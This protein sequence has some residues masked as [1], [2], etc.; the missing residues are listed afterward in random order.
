MADEK[1]TGKLSTIALVAMIFGAL[2]ALSS[3]INL[4][5]LF[6]V[7]GNYDVV[8]QNL[9]GV[10]TELVGTVLFPWLT[11][12]VGVSSLAFKRAFAPIAALATLAGL[13]IQLFGT[14]VSTFF[15]GN[16]TRWEFKHELLGVNSYNE[17][18]LNDWLS[19][20]ISKAGVYVA[21][22]T[23][24]YIL[25][26]FIR[27]RSAKRPKAMPLFDP[28]TGERLAQYDPMTGEKL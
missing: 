8:K 12:L 16:G 1:Q 7:L 26:Q 13:T 25:I 22:A 24:I 4:N 23:S 17:L 27:S 6:W 19:G 5:S 28:M 18:Y 21:L 15:N 9:F 11:I 2:L 14:L 10:A 20:L 3:T